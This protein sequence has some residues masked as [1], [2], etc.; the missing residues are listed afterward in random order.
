MIFPSPFHDDRRFAFARS[1][2]A[3][4]AGPRGTSL[5]SLSPTSLIDIA[6]GTRLVLPSPNGATL[7]LAT[8]RIPTFTGCLR[9]RRAI[10]AATMRCGKRIAVIPAGERWQEDERPRF[11]LED[12]VGAGAIISHLPGR[13]SPEARMAVAVYQHAEEHLLK[14]F[15]Q[16]GSGKELR[17]RGFEAD[18][19]DLATWPAVA[20]PP[21]AGPRSQR[22]AGIQRGTCPQWPHR[23]GSQRRRQHAALLPTPV[24]RQTRPLLPAGSTESHDHSD[25]RP[26]HSLPPRCR[27][28]PTPRRLRF[29]YAGYMSEIQTGGGESRTRRWPHTLAHPA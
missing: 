15:E 24:Y 21:V 11:A 1:I 12:L 10:A 23:P 7:T 9:N 16:C 14:M 20:S 18:I 27:R 5:Y 6:E 26:P 13:L 8:G 4:L 28:S 17:E 3:E 25:H 29:A 2:P 22:Y 19:A